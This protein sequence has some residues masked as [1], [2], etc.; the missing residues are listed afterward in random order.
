M[1]KLSIL[2]AAIVAAACLASPAMAADPVKTL[3]K[4][5]TALERQLRD[6][7]GRARHGTGRACR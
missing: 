2:I 7:E 5:V 1:R 6:A 4:R 3:T